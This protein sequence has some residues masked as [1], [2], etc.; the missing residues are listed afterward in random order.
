MAEIIFNQFGQLQVE[1]PAHGMAYLRNGESNVDGLVLILHGDSVTIRARNSTGR[2]TTGYISVS[3]K[4]FLE[5]AVNLFIRYHGL[6][7]DVDKIIECAE[8][9]DSKLSFYEATEID[10]RRAEA[11]QYIAEAVM[12]YTK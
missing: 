4:T 12:E 7:G 11:E 1:A 6:G 8:A 9:F 5:A 2:I 3:A 10:T